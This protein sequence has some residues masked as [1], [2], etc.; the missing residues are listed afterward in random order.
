MAS[1]KFYGQSHAFADV[2]LN[3]ATVIYVTSGTL[4]A[5]DSLFKT[6]ASVSRC[7]G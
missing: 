2:D 1:L 6:V 7:L 5:D 4:D 3:K